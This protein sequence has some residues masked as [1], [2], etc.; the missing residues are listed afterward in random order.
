M[1]KIFLRLLVKTNFGLLAFSWIIYKVRLF[2]GLLLQSK[3]VYTIEEIGRLFWF[4]KSMHDLHEFVLIY[5][6]CIKLL[7]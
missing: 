7:Y 6:A 3:Y 2:F 1:H 4:V 5:T